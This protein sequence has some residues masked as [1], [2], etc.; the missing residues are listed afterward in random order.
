[1]VHLTEKDGASFI[2]LIWTNKIYVRGL[3]G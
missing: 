2:A 3:A 1:M